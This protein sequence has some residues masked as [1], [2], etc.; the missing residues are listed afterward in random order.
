ME[1][2]QVTAATSE[3]GNSFQT[4]YSSLTKYIVLDIQDADVLVSYTGDP[5]SVLGH[6]LY[7]G[8]SYTWSKVAANKAKFIKAG[9][10]V[11][12]IYATEFT[13]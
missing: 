2:L 3:T 13:D 4:S 6:R 10:T 8:R 1:R 9:T 5:T 11:A 7:A 12:N